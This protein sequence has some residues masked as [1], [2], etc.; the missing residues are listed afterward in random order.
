MSGMFEIERIPEG[1]GTLLRLGHRGVTGPSRAT[2][3]FG[4]PHDLTRLKNATGPST[5]GWTG[6]WKSRIGERTGLEG[7]NGRRR[8]IG[9]RAARHYPSRY[10]IN[11]G[12]C[13]EA[14]DDRRR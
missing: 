2:H 13:G 7:E 8:R 10:R 6:A 3:D 12:K 11:I 5:Y 4:W 1:A 9:P 14:L